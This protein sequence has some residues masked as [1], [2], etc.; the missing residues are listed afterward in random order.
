ME[1]YVARLLK[2]KLGP[3]RRSQRQLARPVS[4]AEA[5]GAEEGV[6]VPSGSDGEPPEFADEK[7]LTVRDEAGQLLPVDR[8]FMGLSGALWSQPRSVTLIAENDPAAGNA[9]CQMLL[10]KRKALH[11]L[12]KS[13]QVAKFLR[14]QLRKFVG[15]TLPELLA[16]NRLFRDMFYVDDIQDWDRLVAYL[17]GQLPVGSTNDAL[18]QQMISLFEE[19]FKSWLSVAPSTLNDADRA[20]IVAALNEVLANR[21]FQPS[22]PSLAV[23]AEPAREEAMRLLERRGPR[24]P[25]ARLAGSIGS[26]WR[27]HWRRR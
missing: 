8:R 11:E 25:L 14:E 16:N 9:P 1:K 12:F 20:R 18:L 27:P 15:M 22:D 23:F 2:G 10:I 21:S 5:A 26:C 6:V 13:P 7:R 3:V 4:A 17:R 19:D 24:R